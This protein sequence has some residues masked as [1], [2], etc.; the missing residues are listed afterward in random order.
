MQRLS[1][2][3]LRRID[4]LISRCTEFTYVEPLESDSKQL[5]PRSIS[6]SLSELWRFLIS[7]IQTVASVCGE[8]SP[9]LRE[10]ERCRER[11]VEYKD[12]DTDT[13]LGVLQAARDDLVAG[14]FLDL[15][16]LVTAEAFGDLLESADHLLEEQYHLPAVAITGAVLESSLRQL[17]TDNEIV[18]NGHSSITK[19][20]TE[21]YKSRIYDKVMFGEI[22]AW[23]KLRNQVAHGDFESPDD[24]D[25]GA[26]KRMVS[27]VRDVV[28]KYR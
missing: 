19:L 3:T 9:H 6:V 18:W 12:L 27:G 11:L 22:E 8:D 28:L 26:A 14:M 23:G 21:L 13:C 25:T 1:E 20:N 5:K 17:A 24:V 16:Q 10:L 4:E 2:E 15:R 7:S